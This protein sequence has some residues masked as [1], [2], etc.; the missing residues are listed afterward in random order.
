MTEYCPIRDGSSE[1]YSDTKAFVFSSIQGSFESTPVVSMKRKTGSPESFPILQEELYSAQQPRKF[2]KPSP[3][4]F[5]W[6]VSSHILCTGL[7]LIS[8]GPES[9]LWQ[10]WCP[11]G[12]EENE[13]TA[14]GRA[15][16]VFTIDSKISSI[17]NFNS[18]KLI[19]SGEIRWAAERK[20]ALQTTV[21]FCEATGTKG[22]LVIAGLEPAC[23]TNLFPYWTVNEEA[24]E[25][26]LSEGKTVGLI[27]PV[28]DELQKFMRPRIYTL[29]ELQERPE[30]VDQSR[31]E[32]YLSDEE[33]EVVSFVVTCPL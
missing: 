18:K 31:L 24:R 28:E 16:N 13:N 23:F 5:Y 14:T 25:A 11:L 27:I 7:F 2:F 4:Q 10:G 6:S 15:T 3:L 21:S 33:F 9:W 30:G 19:G 20:A 32:T 17:S 12:D 8:R 26:N 29:E 22:H 1:Q